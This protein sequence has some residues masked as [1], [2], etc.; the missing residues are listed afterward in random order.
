MH[1]HVPRFFFDYSSSD[2]A[3]VFYSRYPNSFAKHVISEDV[4][5]LTVTEDKIVSY[6]LI[7]KEGSRFF[8][9]VPSWIA[10]QTHAQFMPTL[11]HSVFDRNKGTLETRTWNLSWTNKLHMAE[12]CVYQGVENL[13][14]SV[15]R[16]LT[17]EANTRFS[18]LVENFLMR[19]FRRSTSN[20]LQGY[21]EKLAE[22]FGGNRNLA[23]SS[24]NNEPSPSK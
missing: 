24:E 9:K 3:T 2:V 19:T 23:T 13:R 16:T 10:R 4:L 21:Q 6:K 20:S 1:E 15:D 11:E 7:V 17:V 5:S 8:R 12:H 14:T 22:K 18:N